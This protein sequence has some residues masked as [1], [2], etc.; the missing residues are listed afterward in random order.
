MK[1]LQTALSEFIIDYGDDRK[2]IPEL[3]RLLEERKKDSEKELSREGAI[4]EEAKKLAD[5]IKNKD[6]SLDR[7]ASSLSEF[8]IRYGEDR[9]EVPELRRLIS[10]RKE[11]ERLELL[12]AKDAEKI[13]SQIKDPESLI[14]D[15]EQS[16]NEFID[17]Y[18]EDIEAV[19]EL[20]QLLSVRKEEKNREKM[21]ANE[22]ALLRSKIS[23]QN[24]SV[25]ELQTF[26]DDFI[27]TYGESRT[28]VPDLQIR[29]K[30]RRESD[31]INRL[32]RE[33]QDLMEQIK[34]RNNSIDSLQDSLKKFI[35]DYGDNHVEIQEL[36]RLL[37][38]RQSEDAIIELLSSLDAL[39]LTGNPSRIR[40]IVADSGYANKLAALTEWPGLVFRHHIQFFHRDGDSAEVR[41]ELENGAEHVPKRKLYFNYYF[42][43][44][45]GDWKIKRSEKM[46]N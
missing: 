13:M 8:V 6:E 18:G 28:E 44:D 38:D 27:R 1:S 25:E 30:E 24:Y 16:I 17:N 2:E 9:K 33:A 41:V 5:R 32:S 45:H 15:L 34:D 26:L 39:V 37:D 11:A 40:S 21:I 22:A 23:D 10:E 20:K 43:R 29:L 4:A 3:R 31:L 35:A 19:L 14:Q 46:E 42:L 12:I 36:R 7:I